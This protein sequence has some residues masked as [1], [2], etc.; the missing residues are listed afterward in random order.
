LGRNKTADQDHNVADEGVKRQLYENT[1]SKSKIVS[2]A[3]HRRRSVKRQSAHIAVLGR[4]IAIW[5]A[6]PASLP[7]PQLGPDIMGVAKIGNNR[8]SRIAQVNHIARSVGNHSCTKQRGDRA[9]LSGI[10]KWRGLVL[11]RIHSDSA[12]LLCAQHIFKPLTASFH[13]LAY[14]FSAG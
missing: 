2:K 8:G 4:S 12:R 6:E 14:N 5:L 9:D 3:C 7:T 11:R 13:P 1:F 10:E